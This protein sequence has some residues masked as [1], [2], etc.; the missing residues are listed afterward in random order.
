MWTNRDNA[1]LSGVCLATAP[2]VSTRWTQKIRESAKCQPALIAVFPRQR[3]LRRHSNK[4]DAIPNLGRKCEGCSVATDDYLRQTPRKWIKWRLRR[5]LSP[6][7]CRRI[8]R[9]FPGRAGWGGITTR[10]CRSAAG[11]SA[12]TLSD[13][14][15]DGPGRWNERG[16]RSPPA[17]LCRPE[18]APVPPRHLR[19]GISHGP[20]FIFHPTVE[21]QEFRLFPEFSHIFHKS[22]ITLP[23][24]LLW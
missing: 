2:L 20:S 12:V 5:R 15:P 24:R 14:W 1:N 9:G 18:P 7:K 23:S 17:D 10:P 19:F 4:Q 22:A 6:G 11:A 21:P 13:K 3:P 8:S 16:H